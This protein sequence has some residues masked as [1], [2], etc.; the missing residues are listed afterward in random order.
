MCSIR[1]PQAVRK[2]IDC[3]F[4]FSYGVGETRRVMD[5]RPPSQVA[6]RRLLLV[7]FF[8]LPPPSSLLPTAELVSR[9]WAHAHKHFMF[10]WLGCRMAER[11]GAAGGR[12]GLKTGQWGAR[13]NCSHHLRN[14]GLCAGLR[15]CS[16][17]YV[18]TTKILRPR[19]PIWGLEGG[20]NVAL[21]LG[22][23]QGYWVGNTPLNV[24][25]KMEVQDGF[26]V[27]P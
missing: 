3:L 22:L 13:A 10:S 9:V 5:E 8:F 17:S 7:L 4:V 18:L 16:C 19:G 21:G 25:A 24:I 11:E 1:R 27:P 23:G 15:A 12:W 26:F 2:T 20:L 6:A 14:Y